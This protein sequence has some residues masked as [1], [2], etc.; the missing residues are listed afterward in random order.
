MTNSLWSECIEQD[1]DKLF[2]LH[3]VF[4]RVDGAEYK[5]KLSAQCPVNAIEI[6]RSIPIKHWEKL[7]V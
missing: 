1:D 3:E 5:L 6:A 7:N 2:V 4:T